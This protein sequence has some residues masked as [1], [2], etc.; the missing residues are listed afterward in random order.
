M[1]SI[2]ALAA[3]H[4][5]H[6]CPSRQSQLVETSVLYHDLAAKRAT[7]LMTD[8]ISAPNQQITEDLFLFSTVTLYHG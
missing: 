7:E 1:R 6:Q 8:G 4:L 3:Q 2:L 5:A